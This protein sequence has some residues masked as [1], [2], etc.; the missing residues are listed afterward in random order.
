MKSRIIRASGFWNLALAGSLIYPPL[1]RGLG[2][3]LTQPVWGWLIA[4]FLLYTAITLIL[5]GRDLK[6]FG[7]IILWEGILR[8]FA[9]ALLIPAGLFFGYGAITSILGLAD[10]AWGV[11]FF[12]VV[13]RATGT[14]V[15]K[16]LGGGRFE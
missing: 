11:V 15:R 2:L 7:G 5:C 12:V 1:Y 16:L 10:L 9:A 6:T 3:N 13:P 14:G 4:G 8:F